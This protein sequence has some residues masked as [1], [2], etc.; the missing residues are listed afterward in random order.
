MRFLAAVIALSGISGG[1]AW[2]QEVRVEASVNAE[3]IG[4]EDV[5]ELKISIE[6]GSG[7]PRLPDVDGFR[8]SGRSRSSRVQF[9]GGRMT[10][11]A[12]YTYQLLPQEEGRFTIG[13]ITVEVSGET[14][15]TDPIEVEVVSGSVVPRGRGRAPSPF[16]SLLPR[17]RRNL[18]VDPNDVFLRAELSE[19]SVYQG[20]Q[21]VVTYRLYSRYVPLGPQI[22]DDPPLT[23]FW[24]EEA[25]LGDDDR[26]ERRTVDDKEYLVFPLK[27]RILFPTK[28]GKL[29]VPSV[30][31]STAFRVTS[32]DPFDTFFA[33]GSRPIRVRSS[34]VTLEV[35]P[36]PTAGRP[37][38]F[39]GAVGDYELTAEL[40]RDEVP[41][42]EAVTLT[43]SITGDG[44]LRSVE[45]PPLP[46]MPG[47]RTFDPK[48]DETVRAGRDGL[49]GSKQWEYV[50][51][52]ES[53]GTKEVGPWH[54]PHFDPHAG[55][56]VDATAGPLALMVSGTSVSTGDVPAPAP[57]ER[58]EVR[59]LGRDIRYL[60]DP[61]AS[62]GTPPTA[63][64]RSTLFYVTLAVPILW[65]LGLIAYLRRREKEKTHSTLFRSRRANRMAHRRL[66]RAAKLAAAADK[67]FYEAIAAALYEYVGDKKSVSPSGL[68][69]ERIDELLE[70]SGV[71][72]DT[73]AEFASVLSACE[74]ARFTP[75]RRTR[76]EM[77]ALRARTRALIVSVEKQIT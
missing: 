45:S 21:V 28:S 16:G 53:G 67:A 36:L 52:P 22:E 4:I 2:A 43:L 23:G 61:P 40:N 64:Y 42:G 12:S 72:A 34:P 62:V 75:G 63:Y 24:V 57:S 38:D 29:E 14:H 1:V 19:E 3:R 30:T 56:Y 11:T 70:E 15:R 17:S 69:T 60:K 44:N 46:D 25:E 74:E 68:T 5:L 51:I 77:E 41:V 33:R 35:K 76:D 6:G 58:G 39:S 32:G 73:R 7:D 55:E 47:F 26:T 9:V 20:E 8:V 18:G 49:S 27:R 13:P 71:S 66:K 59:L 54:F 48:T 65:N 31:W 37:R 10:S 50:L